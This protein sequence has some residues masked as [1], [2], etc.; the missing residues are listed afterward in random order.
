VLRVRTTS[1][2]AYSLNPTDNVLYAV[3]MLQVQM[4]KELS[5]E[6]KSLL[7]KLREIKATAKDKK[8]SKIGFG[9]FK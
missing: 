1:V 5:E 8:K 3:V 6:E 2:R 9:L 4:P 7:E